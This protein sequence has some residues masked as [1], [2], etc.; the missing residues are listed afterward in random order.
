MS[1]KKYLP[2]KKFVISLFIAI[3][4]ICVSLILTFGEG[5]LYESKKVAEITPVDESKF[6]AFKQEDT[7]G[8]GLPDWQEG[9]Y[10]TDPKKDDTDGDGTK[11]EDEMKAERDPQKANTAKVGQIPNDK[12][13]QQ[14]IERAKQ[15]EIE[16]EKLNDTQKLARSFLSQYIATQPADRKMTEEEINSVVDSMIKKVNIKDIPDKY[17]KEDILLSTNTDLKKGLE[18][19]FTILKPI[20][21]DSVGPAT[22]KGLDLISSIEKNNWMVNIKEINNITE[23]LSSS[24]DKIIETEVSSL[25]KSEHLDM[26]NAIYKM[27]VH[28]E[29]FK[30]IN[31]DPINTMLGFQGYTDL[32]DIVGEILDK[33]ISKVKVL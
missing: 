32:I 28:L 31:Q 26:A 33:M 25:I 5:T 24:A 23:I 10:G 8:D 3:L 30:E 6:E 15:A 17:K 9:L 12:I 14:I 22:I 7:D 29:S 11:D 19:Y 1:I 27:S 18:K 13:E 16:Y 21:M 4:I 20:I 2:S